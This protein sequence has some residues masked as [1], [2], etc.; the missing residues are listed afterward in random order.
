MIVAILIEWF[1]L[2]IAAEFVKFLADN[3][4]G[5]SLAADRLVKQRRLHSRR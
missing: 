3:N 5:K 1:G 2:K 4:F